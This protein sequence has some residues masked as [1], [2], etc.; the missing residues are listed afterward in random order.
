MRPQRRG[1]FISLILALIYAAT[2][3]RPA[4]GSHTHS[5]CSPCPTRYHAFW[6]RVNTRA[7]SRE[8]VPRV[9][10][11]MHGTRLLPYPKLSASLA[12]DTHPDRGSVTTDSRPATAHR[13]CPPERDSQLHDLPSTATHRLSPPKLSPLTSVTYIFR[14]EK[15]ER[16]R[17]P[18]KLL[19]IERLARNRRGPRAR[20][21]RRE[22]AAAG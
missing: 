5:R 18:A 12:S 3:P 22:R 17:T 15:C 9:M 8:S 6:N 4:V 20:I 14:R 11:G 19:C 2:P 10:H 1:G 7:R 13:C 16:T 21:E